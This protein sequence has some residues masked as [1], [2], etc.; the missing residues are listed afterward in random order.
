MKKLMLTSLFTLLLLALA[1]CGG[2]DNATSGSD[3]ASGGEGTSSTVELVATNWDFAEDT[4]TV[5]AG[6]VTFEL[7]NEEGF[8]GIT[9]NGTD[10]KID[11]EGTATAT[12]EAGEYTIICNV[13]CGEGHAEMT[14]QLVVQ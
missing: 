11:G 2:D 5:P 4:Y 10:V 9:I 8:H 13:P 12:L 14:A 7:I 6:E 3:D 1:A